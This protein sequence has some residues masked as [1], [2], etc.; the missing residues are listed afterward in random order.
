MR[1][2]SNYRGSGDLV[3]GELL[4]DFDPT[5]TEIPGLRFNVNGQTV[6]SKPLK[7]DD[8]KYHQFTVTYDMGKVILYLDGR[9]VGQGEL[10]IG[11]A[12]LY[13]DRSVRRYFEFPNALTEVGIHLGGNLFIGGD[14]GGSFVTYKDNVMAT[15]TAQLTGFVDEI[16]V[17]RKVFTASE[18][19]QFYQ[20]GI[21]PDK[22]K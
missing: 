7:F 5:G 15:P 19:Q 22:Q 4:F 6:L 3:T 9:Q 1:L 10:E 8:G 16:L 12:H 14:T 20:K 21:Q 11:A 13:S 2:F 18:I 17:E